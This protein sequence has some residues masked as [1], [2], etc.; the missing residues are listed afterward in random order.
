MAVNVEM[1]RPDI[2]ESLFKA[3]PHIRYAVNADEY[4]I[5]GSIVHIPQ[6]GTPSEVERNRTVLPGIILKRTDSE[7]LYPLEEYTTDPRLITDIDKKE[8]SY[9]KRQSV[10]REDAGNLMEFIGSDL[11][12]KWAVNVPAANKIVSTGST[13][14][15]ATA[16]GATGTRKDVIEADL[17]AAMVQLD[18]ANVPRDGRYMA[19][20]PEAVSQLMN[21]DKLKYAF[22][23]PVNLQEGIIA[24]LWTFNILVRSTVVV[25][26]NG[27][28]A[29]TVKLP[30][31]A[32]ATTDDVALLFWQ[33]DMVERAMGSIEIFDNP[34]RAEYYGDVISFLVRMGGRNRRSDNKG[35]GLIVLSD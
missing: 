34:R 10:I 32:T 19:C 27:G 3:N 4:V 5:G 13:T 30:E 8:L 18:K 17:R 12:Y 26:S 6:A 9:D 20:T 1:W 31:A 28:T 16:P 2:I 22:Q 23:N 15:T 25:Q 11:L 14:H 29:G 7:I 35:V 21:D 24:K 33:Q